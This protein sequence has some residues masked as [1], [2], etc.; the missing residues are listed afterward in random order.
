[1]TESEGCYLS[2]IVAALGVMVVVSSFVDL[3]LDDVRMID[4]HSIVCP[5]APLLLPDTDPFFLLSLSLYVPSDLGY[6]VVQPRDAR[7]PRIVVYQ[8]GY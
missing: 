1:M 7:Y 5:F 3:L 6:L 8:R 2:D 4:P